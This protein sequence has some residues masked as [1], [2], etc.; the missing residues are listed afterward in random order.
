MYRNRGR[1]CSAWRGRKHGYLIRAESCLGYIYG[2]VV[3]VEVGDNLGILIFVLGLDV[4]EDFFVS[5]EGGIGR[6]L[7]G[8]KIAAHRSVVSSGGAR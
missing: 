6:K 5:S 3:V 1:I 7:G 2:V 4:L 8:T